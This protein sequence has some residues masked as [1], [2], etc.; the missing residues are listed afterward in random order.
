VKIQFHPAADRELKDAVEWYEELERGLGIR[1][2]KLVDDTIL[3][4]VKY[5]K[6]NTEIDP[7]I[8]RALVKK[9]PYGIIYEVDD[10]L[11]S[12][13]AI[14]HLHRFPEYWKSRKS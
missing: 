3:R 11:I 5:P 1:F 10:G 8:Y 12:I 9:F 6:F 2:A 4:L 14:A 7:G 13:Y